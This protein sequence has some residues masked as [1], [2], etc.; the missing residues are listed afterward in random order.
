MSSGNG[1]VFSRGRSMAEQC[2]MSYESWNAEALHRYRTLLK[3]SAAIAEQ[4]NGGEMLRCVR[5]LLSDHLAIDGV[6]LTRL[7][8]GGRTARLVAWDHK[9]AGPKVKVGARIEL[10]GSATERALT[11]LEPVFIPDFNHAML[12]IP[13]LAGQAEL[14][15]RRCGYVFPIA[16]TRVRLGVLIFVG[17][18]DAQFLG[19]D[20]ELMAAAV[21]RSPW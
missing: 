4:P 16:T 17:A 21:R 18:V 5:Q 9:D 15:L 1:L 12:A 14:G 11:E 8:E 13:Q 6:M 19:A 3:L 10:K 2:P 7:E 20:V